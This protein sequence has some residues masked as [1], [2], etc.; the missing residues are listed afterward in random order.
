MIGQEHLPMANA[1]AISTKA[2]GSA[3]YAAGCAVILASSLAPCAWAQSVISAHSGVIHYIEGDVSVDGTPVHPKLAQFLD[4]KPGQLV[5]TAEGRAEILL[6]PGV[7]L[8]MA[9]HS[10]V[11]MLSNSLAD[12]RLEVVSGSALVEIGEL[13]DHNAISFEDSGRHL[14][15]VKKGLYR[16]DASPASLRVYEGRARVSSGS[17]TLTARKGHQID[18]DN[19]Q[20]ANTKLADT[21]FDT[22]ETDAFYRWSS[23]RAEY[24]AA[25]NVISARVTSNSG[26]T[27]GFTTNPGAWSWNPYF[28][29]FTFLPASGVY[30]SPFG[31]PFY[32]P[33]M[34]WAAYMPRPGLLGGPRYGTPLGVTRSPASFHRGVRM[35][36]GVPGSG[37]GSGGGMRGSGGGM[38]GSGGISTGGASLPGARSS[39]GRRR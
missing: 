5:A 23:R 37:L 9:E 35:P 10:S 1:R 11:R 22:K 20:P 38:R 19:A 17:E 30:W 36:R 8:R 6:T 12:T 25:A 34:A 3:A 7:F 21:K 39:G 4:V 18:L 26:Y 14:E 15:L 28:G 27:S 16:I 24:V 2:A 33:G 13:L 32:S 31:S 29:M